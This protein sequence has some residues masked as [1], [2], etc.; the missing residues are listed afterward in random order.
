MGDSNAA[1]HFP[2]VLF[3]LGSTLIYFDS[4]WSEVMPAAIQAATRRLRELGYDL[5][6]GTFPAAYNALI[7]E[8]AQRRDDT[9]IEYTGTAVLEQALLAHGMPKPS[10][11][12]LR[13][14]LKELYC[15]TQEHWHVEDD[16]AAVLETLRARGA[17]LGIIS[18]ASDDDDV[19]TLV[20]NA[21]LR[22]YF[23]F[24]ISSAAVG[25]RKPHPKIF[26]LAL[27]HWGARPDQ[28]VMVGDTVSADVAGAIR[29]GIAN[30]WITRRNNT[31]ENHAAA[32]E[33]PPDATIAALSEL[34][35]LLE[36]WR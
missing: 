4:Q 30:V 33:Y 11:E 8:N 34:P 36:H 14:A 24:I 31:P 15:V 1:P 10:A 35:D 28:A 17:R 2:Y 26:D 5:D 32:Q 13:D 16:A 3:D 18:N 19:Q 12:H 6:A 7:M 22:G 20:D 27:A 25:V 9:F 23:D 29:A 21:D